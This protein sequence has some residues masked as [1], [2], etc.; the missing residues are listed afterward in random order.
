MKAHTTAFIEVSSYR[1]TLPGEMHAAK[2]YGHIHTYKNECKENMPI[3][4]AP[5]L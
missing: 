2:G 1:I 3:K 5:R 4:G